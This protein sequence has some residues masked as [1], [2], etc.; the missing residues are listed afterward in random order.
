MSKLIDEFWNLYYTIRENTLALETENPE[1]FR[2]AAGFIAEERNAIDYF[3]SAYKQND[4]D[5]LR[6]AIKSLNEAGI[7]VLEY[8]L[9]QK[10]KQVDRYFNDTKSILKL[11][12][13]IYPTK[14][15]NHLFGV[16]MLMLES[17]SKGRSVKPSGYYKAAPEFLK[18][19]ELGRKVI[20]DYE[21]VKIEGMAKGD[22]R[23][24]WVVSFLIGV[25]VGIVLLI[26]RILMGG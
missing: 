23:Y 14:V 25:S 22:R 24:G 16:M 6:I 12:R 18:G 5:A 2:F 1:D 10:I 17:L 20:S 13:L 21:N 19:I 9:V 7:D 4:E 11:K 3:A 26:I 8:I 15:R